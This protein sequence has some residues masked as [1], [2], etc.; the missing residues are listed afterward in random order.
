MCE[1]YNKKAPRAQLLSHWSKNPYT[2][3]M[4][5]Y[6]RDVIYVGILFP[7]KQQSQLV[8]EQKPIQVGRI[9]NSN[10]QKTRYHS[11]YKEF[12]VRPQPTKMRLGWTE[13]LS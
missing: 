5:L 3:E 8:F 7:K 6:G 12:R 10:A 13:E 2:V 9:V 1:G 11:G 4:G